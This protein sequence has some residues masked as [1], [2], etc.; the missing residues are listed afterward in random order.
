MN[1][2]ESHPGADEVRRVEV[3]ATDHSVAAY[4]VGTLIV[5]RG[6]EPKAAT[7]VLPMDAMVVETPPFVGRDTELHRVSAILAAHSLVVVSGPPGVGK[8]ALVRQFATV[9]REAGRFDQVFFVDLRGYEDEPADRVQPEAVLTTLLLL[10]GIDEADISPD[11]AKQTV[12]Y[13]ERLSQLAS[14]GKSVLLWLDNASES[15][16]FDALRPASLIH[17]VAITT[18]ET[19]AH[20]PRPQVVGVDVLTPDEALALLAASSQTH[21]PTEGRFVEE[22]KAG[23][24]LAELC[25]RLPLALQIVAALLA[26]E[27]ERPIAE[28]V[29]ELAYEEDRLTSLDYSTDLS[30]RAALALSY[31]RLPENLQRLFR[32]LSVVSGGDVSWQAA[33]WMIESS[34]ARV[35]SQLMAL[36][37]SHLIQQHV[38]DRW[39]MHDLIRL[40]SSELSASEP[41]DA[42][43]AF[44]RIVDGYVLF[45][46][47]TAEWLA[48]VVSDT[49]R[50]AFSSP[51]QAAAWFEA[52]RPTAIAIVMS[53]AK[54]P[55]YRD[56]TL[57][58][59]TLLG[60]I[61]KSQHNWLNDLLDVAAVGASL[62]LQAPDNLGTSVLNVYGGV[63]RQLSRHD[64]A[65]QVLNQALRINEELGEFESASTT[66]S[67]IANVLVAMGQFAAAIDLYWEDIRVCRGSDPPHPYHE[68]ITLTNLGAAFAEAQRFAQALPPLREAMKIRRK[69][70]DR[71]GIAHSAQNLG[72]VLVRLVRNKTERH[73]LEEAVVVLEEAAEIYRE[74]GNESGGAE[75]AANLGQAQCMLRRFAEGFA[76]LESAA[77]YFEESGQT[78]LAEHVREDL[79]RYRRIAENA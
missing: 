18:R 14:E 45:V 40:Y 27:P 64:E 44:M 67:N 59:V 20:I 56:R 8:T 21:N 3:N 57:A 50:R 78:S 24:N 9:A 1:A 22:P 54:R 33:T 28:L 26:D 16:Q 37:R 46:G 41:D 53:A 13:Q 30:V 32:L 63:L 48:A 10:L 25:D 35:R 49:A 68:A 2:P 7:T 66:R 23:K 43:R 65:L 5:Q 52:E 38:R 55:E 29:D 69:L 79:D 62:A 72:G 76:N 36:V 19:F 61:L 6:G 42:A 75:V 60:E 58:L 15:H 31:K 77:I 51:Q 34:A 39:S 47:S 71:P 4:Q 74:R 12:L 70:G 11:A 73:L 17:K